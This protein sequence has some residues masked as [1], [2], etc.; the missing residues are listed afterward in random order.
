MAEF[1]IELGSIYSRLAT[2]AD[3]KGLSIE[4]LPLHY[5]SK[6]RYHQA[7]VWQ[8]FND[9]DLDVIFDTAL[10]GDGK[11]LA[12]QLPILTQNKCALLTYPTNDLIKD[13][14]RQVARYIQE[15]GRNLH[16]DTMYGERITELMEIQ[17]IGKRSSQILKLFS[18]NDVLLT[19]PDLFHLLGSYNYPG[20]DGEKRDYVYAIPPNFDYFIFD[21]FH[22]F[23][24][25][26]VI[27]ILNILNYHRAIGT[28]RKLK[29]IFLSATPSKLFKKLLDNSGFRWTEIAGDY[30]AVPAFG[31]TE[32]P[33]VQ[34]ISLRLHP[35]N[36]KG[37]FAW[38]E[39]HLEELVTFYQANP[40]AK[41]VFIANSV[42]T[43]KR[44]TK[45]YQAELEQ[46]HGIKVGENTGLTSREE[47]DRVMGQDSAVQ[48]IIATSTID[49]GV[50]FKINLLIFE[51]SN[52][53]TFIQR[54]GRLGR[55][56]GWQ[57]Y[58]AY[59]LLPD[60]IVGKFAARFGDIGTSVPRLDFLAAIQGSDK[61]TTKPD[62]AA[63]AGAIFQPDQEFKNY[64]S[65]WGC[66]QTAAIIVKAQS[67]LGGFKSTGDDVKNLREQYNRQYGVKEG[68]DNTKRWVAKYLELWGKPEDTNKKERKILEELTSFRG[69][70]PLACG[71]YDETDGHFKTYDLFFLLAN[72][73]FIPMSESEFRR[74]AGDDFA[75]YQSRELKLYVRLKSYL[76]ERE[77]FTLYNSRSFKDKL[78]Q[79]NVFDNFTIQ[80]NRTLALL[81]DDSVN[82]RL[83]ELSL[84]SLVVGDKPKDFKRR[85][86]LSPLF[87]VYTV[88]DK[89][90][91]LRSVV[92]GMDAL[93]AHSL[94]FYEKPS[95]ED[96]I[97]IC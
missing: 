25:P 40:G 54:L 15:F 17:E 49:V 87:P 89:N 60:W 75:K 22:I 81:P 70:S 24:A 56:E 16:F 66:L 67:K 29:Y 55:H 86:A 20:S 85:K 64:A 46:K 51:S 42:A 78:N 23:G 10:T 77:S 21:E 88:K 43:A 71:I 90:G 52:A 27:S 62:A 1:R 6:L 59:A 48:L 30:S 26:Q 74:K 35:L 11:S 94:V 65:K 63:D 34:P 38:A 91:L 79:I 12:G 13:Q 28:G 36:E 2:A 95:D 61:L 73:E 76:E 80:D 68:E 37:A 33:I 57:E 44:L 8:A 45:F 58:R 31:Y 4:R 39:T 92:F 47:R 69:R 83:A 93:L 53:G 19:N 72:T 97:F 7:R 3:L 41:G 18:S 96:S 50:D 84:V 32:K 14:E 9:P 82:D 5:Q